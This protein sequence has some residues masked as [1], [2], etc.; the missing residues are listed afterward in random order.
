[1]RLWDVHNPATASTAGQLP[2]ASGQVAF[3]PDKDI[4]AV[5]GADQTLQMWDVHEPGAPALVGKAPTGH[6]GGITAVAFDSDGRMAATASDDKTV[7][8][9]N[10]ATPTHL[11]EFGGPVTGHTG[12]VEAVRFGAADAT[13]L[14][15]GQDGSLM[16]WDL[17][18]PTHA[19]WFAALFSSTALTGLTALATSRDGHTVA[20]GT[21]NA[22]VIGDVAPERVA[23]RICATEG[24]PITNQEWSQY[25]PDMPYQPPC[26]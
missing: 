9:W 6:T 24:A 14:S 16:V 11:T 5:A 17:R 19:Q 25:F 13:L 22:T 23:S 15:A 18:D 7:R 4:L 21:A 20:V 12:P 8:L 26:P 10:T 2:G 1:V 3:H